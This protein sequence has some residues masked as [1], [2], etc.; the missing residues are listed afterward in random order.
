MYIDICSIFN[1]DVDFS[2]QL[3]GQFWQIG[4]V[5]PDVSKQPAGL[6]KNTCRINI[7]ETETS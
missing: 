3:I 2:E 7:I 5:G 4:H 6:E 1:F